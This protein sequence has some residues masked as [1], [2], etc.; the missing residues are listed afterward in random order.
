ME[1]KNSKR[2][3]SEVFQNCFSTRELI[4]C[5]FTA[6][7]KSSSKFSLTWLCRR[8][9]I[10]TKGNLSD[11]MRGRRKLSSKYIRPLGKAFGLSGVDLTF[12][13]RLFE[14][15]SC[16]NKE[17]KQ[18][19]YEEL[20]LIRK[21]LRIRWIENNMALHPLSLLVFATFGLF[22]NRARIDQ[23]QQTLNTYD[24]DEVEKAL[25]A[26]VARGLAKSD[27]EYFS[28]SVDQVMFSGKENFEP[29][30]HF[31]EVSLIEAQE[32][33]PKIWKDPDTFFSATI[34]STKFETYLKELDSLRES[35]SR[36]HA[37]LENPQAD[38]LVRVN[39]QVYPLLRRE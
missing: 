13:C 3:P 36:L 10:P 12:F 32:R 7:K 37:R 19:L 24:K 38:T 25:E 20:E 6:R 9:G 27:G 21:V 8:A 22:S 11:V 39:L 31:V 26:L 15:E 33:A 16:R 17:L 29:Q 5:L 28:P 35:V 14:W 23:L 1:L 30:S 18:E 4:Q 2:L 34:L